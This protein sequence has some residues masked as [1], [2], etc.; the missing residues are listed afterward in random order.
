M[1]AHQRPWG[2]GAETNGGEP[3]P[4]WSCE[5]RILCECNEVNNTGVGVCACEDSDT[6]FNGGDYSAQ[7]GD[8]VPVY[9]SE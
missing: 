5:G 3:W 2:G 1:P 4:L 8:Y 9:V 7:I 6:K